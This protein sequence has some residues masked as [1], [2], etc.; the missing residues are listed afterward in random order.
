MKKTI[1]LLLVAVLLVTCMTVTAFAAK[2]GETVTVT[3]TATGS[4]PFTDFDANLTYDSSV[5]T[6]SGAPIDA[7]GYVTDSMVDW[8]V[9][10]N[11]TGTVNAFSLNVTIAPNAEHKTYT[12]TGTSNHAFNEAAEAAGTVTVYAEVT[13]ECDYTFKTEVI[14]PTCTDAGY[15]RHY[16]ECGK[17][18]DDTSVSA[19]GHNWGEWTVTKEA[20]CTEEGSKTRICLN[21]CGESETE[22]IAKVAHN[23]VKVSTAGDNCETNGVDTYTCSVCGDSYTEGNN[24]KGEHSFTDKYGYDKD[25]HWMICDHNS[26]HVTDKQPHSFKDSGNGKEKCE[27]CGYER[28]KATQ[29]TVPDNT[30][31]GGGGDMGDTTP[32]PVFFMMAIAAVMGTAYGFKRKFD[33]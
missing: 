7:F 23:Y 13:V 29:P 9:T 20:T 12:I 10:D 27:L 5:L 3:M 21:G 8:A 22:V 25:G 32:Y 18:I 19:T 33:I 24:L 4:E 28:D 16:C 31:P 6:I 15:T 30:K 17:Y 1:S 11:V 2:A 14:A 26:A